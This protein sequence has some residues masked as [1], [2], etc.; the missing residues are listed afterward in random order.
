MV[1][2]LL[3]SVTAGFR[4]SLIAVVAAAAMLLTATNPADID[5]AGQ[6]IVAGV[7]G[8]M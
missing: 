5:A 3:S 6:A 1:N 8:E 2:G 4:H 7:A